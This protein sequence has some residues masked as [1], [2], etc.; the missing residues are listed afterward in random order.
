MRFIKIII[1]GFVLTMLFIS[2]SV[3]S[4]SYRTQYCSRLYDWNDPGLSFIMGGYVSGNLKF[5]SYGYITEANILCGRDLPNEYCFQLSQYGLPINDPNCF[6]LPDYQ[7][8]WSDFNLG[9]QA[10]DAASG[11]SFGLGDCDYLNP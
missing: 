7:K 8:C 5:D 9:P 2:M 10:F 3:D 6:E 11:Y 1:T 4:N